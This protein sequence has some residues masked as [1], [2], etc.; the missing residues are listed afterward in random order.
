MPAAMTEI[1][2]LND[3]AVVVD[4]VERGVLAVVQAADLV[5]DRARD[6]LGFR[7]K[8]GIASEGIEQPVNLREPSEH[9]GLSRSL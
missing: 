6:K 7:V 5:A 3:A 9:D 8:P 4:P 1:D 2:D